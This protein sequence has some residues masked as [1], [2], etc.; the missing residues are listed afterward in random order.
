MN[1]ATVH[2]LMPNASAPK[3][4]GRLFAG[5]ELLANLGDSYPEYCEFVKK[6]P[7][8]CPVIL[9]DESTNRQL[10]LLQNESAHELFKVFRDYLRSVWRREPAALR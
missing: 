5:L 9:F 8:F 10:E 3:E 4:I 1:N 2:V 7:T 6:Y